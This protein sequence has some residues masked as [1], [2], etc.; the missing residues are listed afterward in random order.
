VTPRPAA[1]LVIVRDSD[2]GMEVLLTKRPKSLRFMGGATVFPGGALSE[3][4]LDPR[5]IEVCAIGPQDAATALDEP[6]G[7]RALGFY[8]A[9]LREAF[10]EVRFLLNPDSPLS[11]RGPGARGGWLTH[12]ESAGSSLTLDRL[13]PAGRWVTPHG[14]NV[15]FDTRFFLTVA[16]EGW[17]PDPD[18][19]EVD[20]ATWSTP[21][22]ALDELARGEAIMAPP[23]AAMLQK[24]ARFSTSSEAFDSI[25]GRQLHAGES[26]YRVKL[27][28]LV[29]VVLAPNPGVMTGPG[30]N[31]YVIGT[32][33]TC[34][35]DPAVGD[36]DYIESVLEIAGDVSAV[37]VT[38]RHSDHVGGVPFV[39]AHTGAPVRAWGDEQAG[40]IDVVPFVDGEII[41]VGGASL[42][43]LFTPGHASDHVSFWIPDES[44]L[45]AGDNVM[46]EGTSVIAPPDGDMKAYLDSLR[47]M[48]ELEPVRIYPGHFRPLD[49]GTE[50]I[51]GYIRH[52]L[53][54][55]RK[56]VAVLRS[57]PA[58]LEQV[59][60]T[61]Y[62]DTPVQL[63]PVAQMSALAHLEALEKDGRVRQKSQNWELVGVE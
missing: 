34:I 48:E 50:V 60:T 53:E 41:E 47:R 42:R 2:P 12:H 6:D 23:T 32:G 22:A 29:Q 5:W 19:S 33:P 27:S 35:V 17:E 24:L 58:T 56:I 44:S 7:P 46:G 54:R 37:L 40:G 57:G 51:A 36:Q 1:T 10:E 28:P 21:Q 25:A 38:H 39:S 30:T 3:E 9:A 26:I 59:V 20:G 8:V 63:H 52:R 15:R 18:P 13:V 11:G 49:D 31:T 55:E 4:D 43:T 62:D 14:S 16:P 61:A 45:V